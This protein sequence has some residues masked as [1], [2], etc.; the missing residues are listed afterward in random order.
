L[1]IES[2]EYPRFPRIQKFLKM[3]VILKK[4]LDISNAADL[5]KS[6]EKLFVLECKY[7]HKLLSTA[8]NWKTVSPEYQKA[9][10]SELKVDAAKIVYTF[11]SNVVLKSLVGKLIPD[12]KNEKVLSH[13]ESLISGIEAVQAISRI[14]SKMPSAIR[15]DYNKRLKNIYKH[16]EKV[17]GVI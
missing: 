2:C 13:L 17:K 5:K 11:S 15:A 9:I 8:L 4:V 16:L 3:D 6:N 7:N 10:I 12:V 14:G 1:A